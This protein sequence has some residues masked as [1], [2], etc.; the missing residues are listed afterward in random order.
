MLRLDIIDNIDINLLGFME[1][2]RG[3]MVLGKKSSPFKNE[4]YFYMTILQA[5]FKSLAL[6]IF[7]I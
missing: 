2:R 1:N 3:I 6:A 4:N 7:I 5:F